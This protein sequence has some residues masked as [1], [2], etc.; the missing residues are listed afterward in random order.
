MISTYIA[1]WVL[2][3]ADTKCVGISGYTVLSDGTVPFH[4][5]IRTPLRKDHIVH[6]SNRCATRERRVA[7]MSLICE[8]LHVYM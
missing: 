5:G 2:L 4:S 6:P 8:T 3:R 7:L 1:V